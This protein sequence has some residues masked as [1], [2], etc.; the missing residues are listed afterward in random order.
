MQYI[1]E[2]VEGNELQIIWVHERLDIEK[3]DAITCSPRVAGFTFLN[4]ILK[5]IAPR[6]QLRAACDEVERR[7]EICVLPWRSNH[8]TVLLTPNVRR[9]DAAGQNDAY[10]L[11]H[12]L[13]AA[14]QHRTIKAKSLGV[15]QFAIRMNRRHILGILHAI[16][17]IQKSSFANLKT[18][19][20][21]VSNE[22]TFNECVEQIL[23]K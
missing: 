2:D 7:Q 14:S 23:I 19:H 22:D 21:I 6:E 12:D 9:S 13:F 17:D 11:M 10:R 8:T 4:A 16:K 15:T 1:I 5:G 20:F 18:I 3:L